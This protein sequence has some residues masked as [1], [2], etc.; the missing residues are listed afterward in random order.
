M[1]KQEPE[2]KKET[3][4]LEEAIKDKVAPLLEQTMEKHWGLSIPKLESD[5]SDRLKQPAFLQLSMYLPRQAGFSKAKKLFRSEFLKQ[6]LRL[7]R[8]NVSSLAK[9]LELDRRSIH[10]AIKDLDINIGN[11][12][13]VPDMEPAERF[14]EK[15]VDKAIRRSLEHYHSLL[16][17]QQLEKVYKE[18][19]ELSRNI[20]KF[21]PHEEVT[22][23]EAEREFERSYLQQTL[24]EH[25]WN[26][27]RTAAAIGLRA[28]TLHRKIKKLGLRN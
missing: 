3:P 7:H 14:Q 22:W 2:R 13:H 9:R 6:E 18:I 28:E 16:Q 15:F 5:I 23:K 4:N 8:G 27:S 17:P 11:I 12:R 21:L 10:R 1:H 19:P 26:I 20:A 25:G 24:A